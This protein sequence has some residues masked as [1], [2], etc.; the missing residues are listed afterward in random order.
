MTR[1][2][3]SL[4][5]TGNLYQWTSAGRGAAITAPNTVVTDLQGRVVFAP[6]AIM[7]GWPYTTFTFFANDGEADSTTAILTLNLTSAPVIDVSSLSVGTNGVFSLS[8]S[9]DTNASYRVW[10]STNLVIWEVL[11]PATPASNGWFQFFDLNS[12]HPPQR[13]YRA[14]TP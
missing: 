14:G 8:F 6:G 7:S 2:V 9:G 10:A 11:G 13:F 3:A 5:A 1:R 12:A 4:P